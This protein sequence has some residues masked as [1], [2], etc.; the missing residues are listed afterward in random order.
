L[1]NEQLRQKLDEHE[2]EFRKNTSP[3]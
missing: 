1:K 2:P 3:Q